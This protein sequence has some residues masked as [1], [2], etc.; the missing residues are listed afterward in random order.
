M[1]VFLIPLKSKKIS[2]NWTN[3]CRLLERCVQ[4]I[5]N[6]TSE[7]F[8]LIIICHERPEIRI[9]HPLISYIE[10]D[11]PP[12]T[13]NQKNVIS[14]MDRDK[15]K[16]M[17]LGLEYASEMKPSHVMFVDADDCVSCRIADFVSRNPH[18]NGW[19]LDSGYVYEDGK[20]RIFYKKNNFYLMS[21]S[22]HIV[23]YDLLRNNSIH[24][25]YLDSDKPLHQIVVNILAEKKI[26]LTPL[27]FAGAVYIIE[28]GENINADKG[29]DRSGREN[30]G[31]FF[32][33]LILKYPRK[34]R[35]LI[36]SQILNEQ[37]ADEFS[38]FD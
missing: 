8:R 20:D 19:F 36:S 26:P 18:A 21:G 2:K 24:S 13:L 31:A 28:N 3:V 38:L 35:T 15:N 11:F 16:K 12:P 1:L 6:Q 7:N 22:S 27:P 32:K 33:N 37:I 34:I 17:W 9:N 14:L 5:V 23:K 29:A 30:G 10:V 4:S 25:I